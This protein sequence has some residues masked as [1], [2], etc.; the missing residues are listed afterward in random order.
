MDDPK[1][2]RYFLITSLS[3][4]IQL[5][6][7]AITSWLGIGQ[8]YRRRNGGIFTLKE[9]QKTGAQHVFALLRTCLSEE[10]QQLYLYAVLL[11]S[12]KSD[13]LPVTDQVL[14][15]LRAL[16]QTNM[17]DKSGGFTKCSIW[18][19]RLMTGWTDECMVSPCTFLKLFF[20]FFLLQISQHTF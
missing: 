19:V 8:S 15:F 12:N 20:F 18:R 6:M 4:P 9:K 2:S 7:N 10:W 3:T 17:L 13:W 5:H 16:Q 1:R 14:P 11:R